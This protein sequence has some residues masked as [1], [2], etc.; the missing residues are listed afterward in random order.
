MGVADRFGVARRR[1]ADILHDRSATA[2]VEFA[3]LAPMF[4][5]TLLAALVAGSVELARAQL[6]QAA[7]VGKRAVLTGN[8]TTTSALQTAI[9]GAI[10]GIIP[11]SQIMINLTPYTSLSS[12]ST[13][14]PVL[15]YGNNGSVSNNWTQNF[16][17]SGSIMVLQLIYQLPIVVGPM[18][19][20]AT[21]S[22]GSYLL[23]STQVF[24]RE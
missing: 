5:A 19:S 1:V 6:D 7:E 15:T 22:N 12:I 3:V 11:C 4:I 21:Q 2:A 17:N 9:C 18:F 23:V 13:S 20:F 16:G 24:V 8:A 14:N 10:G